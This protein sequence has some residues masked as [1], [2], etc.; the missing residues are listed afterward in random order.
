[1]VV[2]PAHI[3]NFPRPCR[4]LSRGFVWSLGAKWAPQRARLG[5]GALGAPAPPP[6]P[7]SRAHTHPYLVDRRL[8][9][10][11]CP[12]R[13]CQTALTVARALAKASGTWAGGG[14]GQASSKQP[15]A[16]RGARRGQAGRRRLQHKQGQGAVVLGIT[17][18]GCRWAVSP[19]KCHYDQV[20]LLSSFTNA[21]P[22]LPCVCP[23]LFF[24]SSWSCPALL[25][26]SVSSWHACHGC[27][28]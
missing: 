14:G 11:V 7:S 10:S 4:Y 27:S 13:A 20:N 6:P 28:W 24:T 21:P 23:P 1:L 5:P 3:R 2:R 17:K 16:A 9:P 19:W 18:Q 25:L 8:E 15:S 22:P 12:P 26:S